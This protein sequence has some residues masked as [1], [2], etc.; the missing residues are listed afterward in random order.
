MD[1]KT[2]KN[3]F[4]PW[5]DDLSD[6][7]LQKIALSQVKLNYNKN[8]I[9]CKQGGFASQIIFLTKGLLKVYKEHNA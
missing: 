5:L 9:L 3:E 8:E 4:S 2:V 6:E 1:I 7:L